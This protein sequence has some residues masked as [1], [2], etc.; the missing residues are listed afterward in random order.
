M[1][2]S[3]LARRLKQA[4]IHIA[5]AESCTGG[6]IASSL[7]DIQGASRWFNQGWVTYSNESKVTQLGVDS[8]LFNEEEGAAG[9]VSKQVAEA[10]ANGAAKTAGAEMAIGVTGIAGPTGATEDKQVGLVWVSVYLKGETFSRQAEFGH[11]D[12]HS[13]KEAFATFALRVALEVWE[14]PEIVEEPEP[15]EI[16]EHSE[17]IQSVS[18][19][20][21]VLSKDDSEDWRGD[22]SWTEGEIPPPEETPQN[23]MEIPESEI[24]WGD[25]E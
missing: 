7:T 5:T 22:V 23:E 4:K 15:K 6:L 18:K 20:L 24:A 10:M 13:N 2:A 8:S 19:A 25:E 21:N 12:R 14:E 16:I 1:L 11:G 17:P 9:A 3:V